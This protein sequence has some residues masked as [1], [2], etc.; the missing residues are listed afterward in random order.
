VTEEADEGAGRSAEPIVAAL[1][2]AAGIAPSPDE[3]AALARGYPAL[4][5]GL[6]ALYL[7]EADAEP[8]LPAWLLRGSP[9][10]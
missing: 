10:R 1:L 8:P 4:R 3:V 6:D 9:P 5:A 7:P 2:A